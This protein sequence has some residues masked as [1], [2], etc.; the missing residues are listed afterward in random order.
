[1]DNLADGRKSQQDNDVAILRVP[2]KR[3]RG[4]LGYLQ[5]TGYYFESQKLQKCG[6]RASGGPLSYASAPGFSDRTKNS[7]VSQQGNLDMCIT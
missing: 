2:R 7:T 1:M 5:H 4:T 6:A 3:Y